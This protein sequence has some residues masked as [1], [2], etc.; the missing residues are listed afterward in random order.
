MNRSIPAWAGETGT[1]PERHMSTGVYPRVGG[2]NRETSEVS[3]EWGGLS[4]RGRGKLTLEVDAAEADR[5]IPAWA[6]E[7]RRLHACPKH[8]GVY[9]RVG[10]GNGKRY[11]AAWTSEGLSPRGRGK[12]DVVARDN[13]HPR[14]IPAWAGETRLGRLGIEAGAVYPRVGGGNCR[15]P[16]CAK[17][18]RGLSPRGRGKLPVREE[19]EFELRSIPAWAGET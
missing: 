14:S 16:D 19:L 17:C 12:Q 15:I 11:A 5:S 2:G 4:P 1:C 6:G 8:D 7:T 3:L 9:P 18:A 13:R 10:G